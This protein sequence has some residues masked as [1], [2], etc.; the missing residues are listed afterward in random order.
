MKRGKALERLT[1]KPPL[2]KQ[3]LIP[4]TPAASYLASAKAAINALVALKRPI[5][6]QMSTKQL[7]RP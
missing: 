5:V 3:Q 1:P 6:G 4:L 7:V 2:S